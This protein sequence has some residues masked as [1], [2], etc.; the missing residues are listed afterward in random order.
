L[1]VFFVVFP[2]PLFFL[3]FLD[4]VHIDLLQQLL[5]VAVIVGGSILLCEMGVDEGSDCPVFI[6]FH[7]SLSSVFGEG[8]LFF[9]VL[10][11]LI[12]SLLVELSFVVLFVPELSSLFVHFLTLFFHQ[13]PFFF[14][15]TTSVLLNF[16]HVVVVHA[17]QFVF[18]QLAIAS[19]V[20]VRFTEGH[21]ALALL[22]FAVLLFLAVF[23]EGEFFVVAADAD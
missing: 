5:F 20:F 7:L 10:S 1:V 15:L 9:Q 4:A 13:Y 19:V 2:L 21:L 18:G 22:V 8:D 6:F 3:L 23:L 12:A 11:E 14:L 17:M 16:T